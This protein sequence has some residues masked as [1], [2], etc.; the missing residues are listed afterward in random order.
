MCI[1]LMLS[2]SVG[3]GSSMEINGQHHG[4]VGVFTLDDR[5]PNACYEVIFGNVVWSVLLSSTIFVPVYLV[6]WSIM[7]PVGAGPCN[8]WED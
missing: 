1:V 7:E 6:G 5:D 3:C 8:E 4:T 2:V